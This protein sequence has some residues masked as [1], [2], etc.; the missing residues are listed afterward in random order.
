MVAMLDL[1][2]LLSRSV[3]RLDWDRLLGWLRGSTSARYVYLL[4]TYL[5]RHGLLALPPRVIPSLRGSASDIDTVTLATLHW[6]VDRY[7]VAG[8]RPRFPMV[9]RNLYI[10]WHT[11]LV[12]HPR[13]PRGLLVPWNLLPVVRRHVPT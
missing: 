3:D 5:A 6:L 11:L 12:P 1:I 13:L 8:C 7:V 2:Y 4:L 10:A 9:G